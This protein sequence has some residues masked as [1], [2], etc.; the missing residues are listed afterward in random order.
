M[1]A[2]G[3]W[4]PKRPDQMHKPIMVVGYVA[5]EHVRADLTGQQHSAIQTWLHSVATDGRVKLNM[6]GPRAEQY[7]RS[8]YRN[9]EVGQLM[10]ELKPHEAVAQV[11]DAVDNG[12]LDE[13][14][15]FVLLLLQNF[16]TSHKRQTGIKQCCQLAGKQSD[17][18][19]FGLFKTANPDIFSQRTFLFLWC[20]VHPVSSG[21]LQRV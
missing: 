10:N 14:R 13:L 16:D 7:N 6:A 20:L 18:R 11:M 21:D 15:A 3:V 17:I 19:C 8:L 1:V 4:I 5:R 12:T 9:N 2:E